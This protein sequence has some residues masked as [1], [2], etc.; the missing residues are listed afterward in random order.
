MLSPAL[1]DC[2]K[3]KK[4]PNLVTLDSRVDNNKNVIKVIFEVI[5][6]VKLHGVVDV[7]L[8]GVVDVKLLRP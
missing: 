1:N 6:E 2:P 8:R 5:F 4:S 3:C 7:K